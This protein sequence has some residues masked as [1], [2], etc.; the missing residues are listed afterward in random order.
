MGRGQVSYKRN[1]CFL[2]TFAPVQVQGKGQVGSQGGA[3]GGRRSS[4]GPQNSAC[5]G[6]GPLPPRISTLGVTD[7][8]TDTCPRQI[9]TLVARWASGFNKQLGAPWYLRSIV[10]RN[11]RQ[12]EVDG[13]GAA[14]GGWGSEA[15]WLVGSWGALNTRLG[16]GECKAS[17]RCR[18][19]FL[20]VAPK[21][22]IL[23]TCRK[24]SARPGSTG[25]KHT[26]RPEWETCVSH[27]PPL[28]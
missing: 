25:L 28:G 16:A 9:Q 15:G 7:Q 18:S 8:N 3:L 19:P 5:P 2:C 26:N 22:R 27:P 13:K 17:V 21:P 20:P 4:P 6:A 10:L 14:G 1:L 23:N 11:W 24:L 12:G